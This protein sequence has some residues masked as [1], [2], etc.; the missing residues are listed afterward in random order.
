MTSLGLYRMSTK[1]SSFYEKKNK[2]EKERKQL[3]EMIH[4]SIKFT[5]ARISAL[6]AFL[7]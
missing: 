6:F 2:R 4:Y 7:K 3:E 1:S 5:G